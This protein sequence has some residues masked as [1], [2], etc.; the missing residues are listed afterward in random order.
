MDGRVAV[1]DPIAHGEA[2][3]AT[4]RTLFNPSRGHQRELPRAGS[5]GA[6]SSG[7]AEWYQDQNR[8]VHTTGSFTSSTPLVNGANQ[9]GIVA[10]HERLGLGRGDAQRGR[11]LHDRRAST[12]STRRTT[13]RPGKLQ[14]FVVTATTTDT[15]GAMTIPIS[16]PIIPT[17]NLQTVTASPANGA[18]IISCSARRRS[19]P[20]RARWRRPASPNSLLFHPEAFILAMADLDA[21]LPTA[22]RWRAWPTTR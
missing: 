12:R 18:A 9:T 8:Y 6:T 15:A 21:D 22:R 14:Q 3:P 1:L 2:D 5:S 16:P 19:R 10:H 7:I 13:P 20:A 17:G 4:P 11:R